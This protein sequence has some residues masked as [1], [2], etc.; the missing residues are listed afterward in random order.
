MIALGPSQLID[1]PSASK[2]LKLCLATDDVVKKSREVLLDSES[3]V[4]E[5]VDDD[6]IEREMGLPFEQNKTYNYELDYRD[7]L[8]LAPMVRS[9]TRESV[10]SGRGLQGH[11]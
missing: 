8:V 3:L 9:G 2:K 5:F 6:M 1:L 11:C 7:K 10:F 4:E